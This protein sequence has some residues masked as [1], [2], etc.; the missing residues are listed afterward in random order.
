MKIHTDLN[1]LLEVIH[2]YGRRVNGSGIADTVSRLE[3]TYPDRRERLQ[4]LLSKLTQI[5]FLLDRKL[6]PD[7]DRLNFFFRR[8]DGVAYDEST[9]RLP[10]SLLLL[11]AFYRDIDSFESLRAYLHSRDLSEIRSEICLALCDDERQCPRIDS[12]DALLNFVDTLPVPDL[13]KWRILDLCN[14]FFDYVEELI[15]LLRPAVALVVKKRALFEDLIGDYYTA[16][17]GDSDIVS[18]VGSL[19][20]VD[21]SEY[22]DIELYP[23]VLG[24]NSMTVVPPEQPSA[25]LRVYIGVLMHLVGARGHSAEISAIAR[26]MKALGDNSRLEMLCSIRSNASYGQDLAARFGVSSTTVYHH[27]NKLIVAGLVDSKIHGNRV[28]FSMNRQNIL[29]LIEQTRSLLLDE[30]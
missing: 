24:F 9:D 11:D 15:E 22:S 28:Y 30:G 2:Y 4:P 1:P 13:T 3:H 27:M 20:S 8:L 10:A 5:E 26:C 25:P 7:M 21:L 6:T 14:H 23:A 16:L 29:A 17:G 19:M 18:L 12:T